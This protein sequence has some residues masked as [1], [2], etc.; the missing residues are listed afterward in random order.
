MAHQTGTASSLEDL[1]NTLEIFAAANG[2]TVDIWSHT[3]TPVWLHLT[4]GGCSVGLWFTSPLAAAPNGVLVQQL[5]TGYNSADAYNAQPHY[6]NEVW[7]DFP[8]TAF[9]AYWL[10][11]NSQY[12]HC[13]VETVSGVYRHFCFGMLNKQGTYTGGSYC[14]G[15]FWP[16]VSGYNDY[17]SDSGNV[18]GPFD[19]LCGYGGGLLGASTE[20]QYQDGTNYNYSA[21]TFSTAAYQQFLT[22]PPLSISEPNAWG[23]LRG[24]LYQEQ[25]RIGPN[26]YNGVAVLTPMPYF[27]SIVGGLYQPLGAPPNVRGIN[28]FNYNPGDTLSIG[29]NTWQVFPIASKGPVNNSSGTSGTT[30]SSS[31]NYGIAHLVA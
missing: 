24:G 30:P 9:S 22:P 12:I 1:L 14:S 3:G 20:I 18:R 10:Y 4:S 5:D 26:T 28:I 11:G 19:S 25:L 17:Y 2:W 8:S 23:G 29:S 13:V 27:A 15:S 31:G 21:S 16:H 7:T 6:S